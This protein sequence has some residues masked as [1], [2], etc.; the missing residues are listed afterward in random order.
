M[1]LHDPLGDRQLHL[2]VADLIRDTFKRGKSKERACQPDFEYLITNP[3][4]G[5]T[6]SAIRRRRKPSASAG[7]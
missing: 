6:G 2:G 4:Y 5:R 7:G 1:T 3:P